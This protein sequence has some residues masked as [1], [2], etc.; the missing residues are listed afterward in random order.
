MQRKA[1]RRPVEILLVEDS[2]SDVHLT[3]VAIEE[4]G[5]GNNLHVVRNGVEAIAFVRRQGPY[6]T[7]PRPDLVLLDLNL[8]GKNGFEVL[9]ELKTNGDL[10]RIP[11][12]V[13]ST[14]E[15]QE[16]VERSYELQANCY[17]TKPT[18]VDRFIE[19][20]QTIQVFWSVISELPPGSTPDRLDGGRR[21][22]SIPT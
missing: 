16:D 17:V 15:L 21:Q 5:T 10:R 13:L 1:D 2:P 22:L 20:I 7:A 6:A 4:S 3:H 8:P 12:V 14:S 11:V 18:D 9:K 19:V